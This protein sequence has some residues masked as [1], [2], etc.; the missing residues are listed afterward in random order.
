MALRAAFLTNAGHNQPVSCDAE[1]VFA[2]HG[3]AQALQLVALELDERITHRAVEMVVLRVAVVVLVDGTAAEG[4]PPKET[5]F[6]QFVERAIHGRPAHFVAKLGPREVGDQLVGVEMVVS[7]KNVVDQRTTLL[8]DPLAAALEVL[9][10][11]LLRGTGD[12]NGA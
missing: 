9:R 5:R 2:P 8:G 12:L 1:A 3:V 7:F 6:D 11:P 10:E 4:H